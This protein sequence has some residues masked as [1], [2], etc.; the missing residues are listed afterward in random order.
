MVCR[1]PV[2]ALLFIGSVA[3]ASDPAQRA[4]QNVAC[5]RPI[6]ADALRRWAIPTGLP[7]KSVFFPPRIDPGQRLRS[8]SAQRRLRRVDST[9]ALGPLERLVDWDTG[10]NIRFASC[11]PASQAMLDLAF[12]RALV[13]QELTRHHR[14]WDAIRTMPEARIIAD[15]VAA[16]VSSF[17]G[18]D[19]RQLRRALP[20]LAGYLYYPASGN[21][22]KRLATMRQILPVLSGALFADIEPLQGRGGS[23]PITA[24]RCGDLGPGTFDPATIMGSAP[25]ATVLVCPGEMGGLRRSAAFMASVVGATAEGGA[26]INGWTRGNGPITRH[27]PLDAVG[28]ALAKT[29]AKRGTPYEVLIKGAQLPKHQ[30]SELFELD[31]IVD[32]LSRALRGERHRLEEAG[33]LGMALDRA[34]ARG[35][36]K[37]IAARV[38]EL[39][40]RLEQIDRDAARHLRQVLAEAAASSGEHP[41]KKAV[42]RLV[43]RLGHEPPHD[44]IRLGKR[45]KGK[46]PRLVEPARVK[47]GELLKIARQK[48]RTARAKDLPAWATIA[49]LAALAVGFGSWGE[50]GEIIDRHVR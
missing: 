35:K 49:E 26:L 42:I 45:G 37:A 39:A 13:G 40:G 41:A 4:L 20:T 27:L 43:S 18:V 29:V 28:L 21:D 34:L 8:L 33:S 31:F 44:V 48:E 17:F 19:P 15:A 14:G 50:L 10:G 2:A 22:R 7:H 24:V 3:W 25:A 36:P 11:S 6:S 38:G 32:G 1:A 9:G 5:I 46:A 30:L 47:Y 23:V 12:F 16:S